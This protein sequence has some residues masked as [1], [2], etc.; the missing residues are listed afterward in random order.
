M[1]TES[2]A[3]WGIPLNGDVCDVLDKQVAYL[4]PRFSEID[5]YEPQDWHLTLKFLGPRSANEME[6]FHAAMQS[7]LPSFPPF[8]MVVKGLG[9]F[10]RRGRRSVL[11][12]GVELPNSI[13]ENL[14][15]L[16]EDVH[17]RLGVARETRPYNP[18]ITLGRVRRRCQE[19]LLQI[20]EDLA[21]HSWG[22]QQVSQMALMKRQYNSSGHRY[23]TFAIVP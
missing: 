2:N 21:G 15:S 17:A 14:V 12:A 18:H 11:W 10:E 9:F 20:V 19:D 4:R 13:L 6:G 23:G 8:S 3:F 16:L 7:A 1:T 5:W 22:S